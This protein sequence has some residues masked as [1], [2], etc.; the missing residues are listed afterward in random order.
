LVL[1][2]IIQMRRGRTGPCQRL[3]ASQGP[4][5]A[6]EISHLLSWR[7]RRHATSR[8]K[9]PRA[10]AMPRPIGRT[11]DS[12]G[13]LGVAVRVDPSALSFKLFWS[14]S[15]G[16]GP[17]EF[18]GMTWFVWF[19]WSTYPGVEGVPT[20]RVAVRVDPS[21]LLI[22][23][24]WSVSAGSGSFQV[25]GMTWFGLFGGSTDPGVEGMSTTMTGGMTTTPSSD[26]SPKTLGAVVSS[27]QVLPSTT[28]VAVRVD[29]SALS[30]QSILSVSADSGS[31]Q[32]G[33]MTWFGWFGGSTNPGVEGMS[34]THENGR[35][36][37]PYVL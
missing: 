6:S 19:G 10:R 29:P 15:A 36:V 2:I 16:S 28:R 33:G 34:T 26:G 9:I 5:T 12:P 22:Q 27:V 31:F 8:T 7:R 3:I 23:L 30:L 11:N 1:P 17:S 25:G 35:T 14:V 13:N 18:G 24:F 4:I 37:P 21:A 32:V 20:T